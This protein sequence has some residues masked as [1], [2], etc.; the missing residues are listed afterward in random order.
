MKNRVS[1]IILV[2]T[3]MIGV[4]PITVTAASSGGQKTGEVAVKYFIQG[5]TAAT[6]GFDDE[7]CGYF[8]YRCAEEV[9]ESAAMG[10]Y[11]GQIANVYNAAN[12]FSV[13]AVQF[14]V[15]SDQ[16]VS[17][18]QQY[19]NV[20]YGYCNVNYS[21]RMNITDYQPQIGDVVFYD[22]NSGGTDIDHVEIVT[23]YDD[24]ALYSV[25]GNRGPG[26]WS[27]TKVD[28]QYTYLDTTNKA[29]AITAFA[30]PNY[31]NDTGSDNLEDPTTPSVPTDGPT[32]TQYRYHRYEDPVSHDYFVCAYLGLSY[33][34]S[35]QLVYSDW[36][37]APLP[38]VKKGYNDYL[39][40]PHQSGCES[41]GCLSTDPFEVHR[42]V[43]AGGKVWYYE[44][45]RQV[46]VETENTPTP[47]PSAKPSETVTPS[48]KPSEA[49]TPSDTVTPSS[50]PSAKP[51]QPPV[52][53]SEKPSQPPATPSEKPAE[54]DKK[55]ALPLPA[56]R[57]YAPDLFWDV[58]TDAWF[59]NNVADA[60]EM[61]LM[62]GTGANS[63]SPGNNMT[64]AEAVTLAARIHSLYH[65]GQES[66]ARYD[67][68]SW[69]DPY[70][71]YARENQIIDVNYDYSRPATREEFVHI[72]ARALPETELECINEHAMF[73]DH[74]SVVYISDVELLSKAGIINGIPEAGVI[75]FKPSNTITRAEVAAV[76][77]RMARPASRIG[78]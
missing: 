64:L 5:A 19:C 56:T 68:G 72:L 49:A 45:T 69:Y 63:F 78:K 35:M 61:G 46:A 2:L 52:T 28:G 36:L 27:T 4:L 70:V 16:T 9:G 20:N 43:D 24:G 15:F 10:G 11:A 37:D 62:N 76:V 22:W 13:N 29:C 67:G 14:G 59:Y 6:F 8:L 3:L 39:E 34:P 53:P 65:N 57:S 33:Y 74:Q 40:H 73:D 48:L 31:S 38:E 30:R 17:D 26:Y 75:R 60:Y 42:H 21:H 7:W 51:S 47:I 32:K 23:D 58:K 55:G 71:D 50:S 1:A 54:T 12:Y 18:I 44:E 66:F 41:A 25:G 77:A